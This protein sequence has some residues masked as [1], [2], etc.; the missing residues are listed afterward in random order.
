MIVSWDFGTRI[1]AVLVLRG[2][3]NATMVE[4]R[5]RKDGLKIFDV[6]DKEGKEYALQIFPNGAITFD[7]KKGEVKKE[8]TVSDGV[9]QLIKHRLE[10]L[11]KAGNIHEQVMPLAE[12]ML[13]E[14]AEKPKTK[15]KR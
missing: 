12:I 3:T 9:L 15:K 1:A 2:I 11:D 4:M 8:Y 5:L 7:A 6:A 13:T 14:E 10:A